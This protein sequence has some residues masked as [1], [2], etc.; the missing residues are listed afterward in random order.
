MG[1]TEKLLPALTAIL[2]GII[3]LVLLGIVPSKISVEPLGAAPAGVAAGLASSSIIE[4]GPGVGGTKIWD[5]SATNTCIARM[6][7]TKGNNIN[8]YFAT[9]HISDLTR[10]SET[11]GHLQLAS[12][13]EAY[14]AAI[15]GCGTVYGFGYAASTTITISE[16][17]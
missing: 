9:S 15:W 5:T 4:L 14:D 2:V 11:R 7:S 3:A 10:P 16:S 6:I 12:T 8:L 13:T 1:K 17:K